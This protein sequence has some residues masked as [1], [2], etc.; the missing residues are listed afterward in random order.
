VQE[1]LIES[2]PATFTNK[3]PERSRERVLIKV[4][5]ETGEIDATELR[6][7]WGSLGDDHYGAIMKL[8]I[9]TGAR[10]GEMGGLQW[11]EVDLTRNLISLPGERVKNHRPHTIPLSAAARTIIEAQP[12]RV[13]ADG[14]LR[15]LIFGIGRGPFAGWAGAKDSL[16]ERVTKAA[17]GPLP[18]WRPH[19]LRRTVATGMNEIGIQPHIVEAALNHVS[20]N[21]AGVAGIYNRADYSTEKRNALNLW[22]DRVLAWADD[23]E[24]NVTV[25]RRA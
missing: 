6:L 22:A 18:Y 23:R 1:G 4:D 14:K 9:L 24:A 8:L 21:R 16:D 15:K 19:D 20:G 3:N 10:A 5:Q 2:N 13:G 11:P 12:Q 7:I 17:G 25:L